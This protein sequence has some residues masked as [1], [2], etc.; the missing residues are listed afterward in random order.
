MNNDTFSQ[1][2]ILVQL[3]GKVDNMSAAISKQEQLLS[4]IHE[5]SA[6]R[7]EKIKELKRDVEKL[8]TE[9]TT[10]NAT[11]QSLKSFNKIIMG[12]W[13]AVVFIISVFGKDI[14]NK[15]F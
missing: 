10:L 2:E 6:G 11:V 14:F 13:G 7:D 8:Q 1:K 4:S 15:I 12:A 5:Q 3:M 9:M